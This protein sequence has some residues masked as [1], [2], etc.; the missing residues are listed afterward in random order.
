MLQRPSPLGRGQGEGIKGVTRFD[1]LLVE[2]FNFDRREGLWRD[3]KKVGHMMWSLEAARKF[4]DVL[5]RFHPDIVH[6][7]NIYHHLS[8]SILSVAKRRRVPIVMTVHDWHL[9]N[10]NYSLY[11]HGAICERQGLAA[12]LHRCIKNSFSASFADVVE[13]AAHRLLRVYD[14]NVSRYL[15]PTEFVKNKLLEY[16][17]DA[18]KIDVVKLPIVPS[19]APTGVGAPSPLGRGRAYR[20]PSPR[21]RGQGEGYG[22]GYVLFA[23]RLAEEKGI[24]LLL[25]IA[26][27]LPEIQFK[28]AGDG[29]ELENVKCKMENEKLLNVELLGFVE[30]ERLQELIA[31]A[32]LV[33]VPSLWYEPSPLSVLEAMAA[34]KVVVA[35]RIGG[36]PD[37]IE[38]GRTGF[39]IPTNYEPIANIRANNVR[40]FVSPVRQF[41]VPWIDTIKKVYYDEALLASV[42]ASAQ[43]HVRRIHD[44]EIHYDRMMKIYREVSV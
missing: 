31:G 38:D 43:D 30:N 10:P 40:M 20:F 4:E 18:G 6:V 44:P 9:I 5:K 24:Y 7:H 41:V 16:G 14:R 34:G 23:G 13:H 11:D 33:V 29:P 19:P 3:V 17:M 1:D 26:K 25:E 8:P 32:R 35:S 42:G 37:L 39:L 22:D 21:G 15:V 27:Q 28:I 12:L 2:P 36:I